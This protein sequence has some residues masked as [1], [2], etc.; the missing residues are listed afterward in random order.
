[1]SAKKDVNTGYLYAD[2]EAI[3]SWISEHYGRIHGPHKPKNGCEYIATVPVMG[4]LA[5]GTGSTPLRA[6]WSL[7]CDLVAP[8]SRT[9]GTPRRILIDRVA[10]LESEV[11]HLRHQLKQ[12]R[13]ES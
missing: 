3:V 2:Q 12:K 7:Y 4:G 13:R 9:I 11:D 8:P 10:E 5:S 1:M 6:L